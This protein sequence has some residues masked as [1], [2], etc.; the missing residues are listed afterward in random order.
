MIRS[1]EYLES[2]I[3]TEPEDFDRTLFQRFDKN[4]FTG[5]IPESILNGIKEGI[6]SDLLT[7]YPQVFFLYRELSQYLAV[8]ENQ[9]LITAGS[10]AGIKNIFE[11]LIREGDEV[12]SPHPTYAMYEVYC[13]LYQA[14][15]TKVSYSDHLL[16]SADDLIH[17]ITAN[18]RLIV[19]ANPNSPT[20]TI[21]SRDDIIRI[22]EAG[23]KIGAVILVD[24]AYYLFYQESVLDLINNYDNLFVLRTFS[25]AFALASCR[26]GYIVSGK[27]NINL[28]KKFKPIYE[29]NGFAILCGTI[30]LQHADEVHQWSQEIRKSRDIAL[31]FLKKAGIFC[32]PSY[33]NFINIRVGKKNV[34]PIKQL[35]LSHGILVKAGADHP[36]LSDCIRITI[37]LPDHTKNILKI[38]VAYMN[39]HL[40]KVY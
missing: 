10:D 17:Q 22:I 26:L 29:T 23:E 6:T 24:E 5:T 36:A 8:P 39:K 32:Y 4:E 28:L 40:V 34:E 7:A 18:T 1:K 37:G 20:G 19:I 11:V 25:K 3:R 30:F 12:L 35:F 9:I 38:L 27:D 33:T 13:Q 31:S 14:R 21:F 2:I 15:I 16:L